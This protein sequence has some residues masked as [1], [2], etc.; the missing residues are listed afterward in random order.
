MEQARPLRVAIVG[1]GLMGSWHA[2]AAR[3]A[4]ATITL[5][6]DSSESRAEALA[7]KFGA[8][9][10]TRLTDAF[11]SGAAD[12]VHICTPPADH[13]EQVRSAVA[14][15]L[16][17]L[18]EKPLAAT[19]AAT[20]ELYSLAASKHVLLCPVHQFLYQT[21]TMR[22]V[23][24]RPTL[25]AIRQITSLICSA[26]ASSGK[27]ADHDRLAFDILPHPL[28]LA[29]RTV[30]SGLGNAHWQT[31]RSAAGEIQVIGA[32]DGIAIGILVSTHSRPTRNSFRVAGDLATWHSDLF[33]G[34]GFRESGRVSRLSKAARPFALAG[35][36]F[37]AAAGN[38]LR[39]TIS[40]EVAFPGL[41]ELVSRFY[42]AVRSNGT[43]P[44]TVSESLEV[45]A[46]RDT[47][48]ASLRLDGALV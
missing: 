43:S 40:A 28:S 1:A 29:V 22:F 47:I 44:I 7:R 19:A 23:E 26:G 14:S 2:D 8:T 37:A 13:E 45:A 10:T 11:I 12:I 25:G 46:A 9:P 24:S 5:I 18:V 3:R 38:A 6:A 16:H 15:G 17:A 27:D 20:A 36:T 39:R 42:S 4:N 34:F 41:R 30:S 32:V 33:H 48:I 21:G 31:A 35:S